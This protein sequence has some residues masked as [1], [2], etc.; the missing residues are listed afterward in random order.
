MLYLYRVGNGNDGNYPVGYVDLQPNQCPFAALRAMVLDRYRYGSVRRFVARNLQVDG[1]AEY[2]VNATVYEGPRG[3]T[4]FGA[5][6][7]TAELE[8]A[9]S[10]DCPNVPRLEFPACLDRG[11]RQ[12][13][14]RENKRV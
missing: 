14:A 6:W 5:A 3:E 13:F 1:E 2:G 4:H 12:F 9:E 11:A 8:P 7:I 10:D